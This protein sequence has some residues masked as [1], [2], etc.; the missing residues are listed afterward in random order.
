[1][2]GMKQPLSVM[3]LARRAG[4]LRWGYE[5]AVD[6]MRCGECRLALTACDLSDKTKKNVRFEA[7]RYGVPVA[8]TDFTMEEISAAIGKKT[9]VVAVCGEGFA[10]KPKQENT[11]LI[12][13]CVDYANFAFEKTMTKL[14]RIRERIWTVFK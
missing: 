9:G 2:T 7:E 6:A 1:M 14:Q 8:E 12:I 5:T 13:I 10:E 3:G 11:Q 4:Q